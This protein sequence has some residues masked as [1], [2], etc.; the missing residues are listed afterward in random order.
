M[1][2]SLGELLIRVLSKTPQPIISVLNL[3]WL[4]GLIFC[5][6][7]LWITD[8]RS[9]NVNKKIEFVKISFLILF[10]D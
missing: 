8:L 7:G 2:E 3:Y 1:P 6:V 5:R 4:E 10:I 9:I